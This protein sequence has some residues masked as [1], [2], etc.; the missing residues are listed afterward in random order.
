[1][2]WCF[3]VK[4]LLTHICTLFPPIFMIFQVLAIKN[5]PP[6][7]WAAHPALF[8]Y[9]PIYSISKSMHFDF[10]LKYLLPI[11]VSDR[12]SKSYLIF[13]SSYLCKRIVFAT[14]LLSQCVRYVFDDMPILRYLLTHS[15]RS[16]FPQIQ[17]LLLLLL[18]HKYIKKQNLSAY[19]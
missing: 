14:A 6:F 1:M 3:I 16:Y 10:Y 12:Y 18:A 13:S 2:Y 9:Q 8:W 5:S 17:G 11:R 19:F 15:K 7:S 4:R